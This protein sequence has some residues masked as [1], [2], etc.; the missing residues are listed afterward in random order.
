MKQ[1]KSIKLKIAIV[2]SIIVNTVLADSHI[3]M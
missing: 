1:G 2:V 3:F